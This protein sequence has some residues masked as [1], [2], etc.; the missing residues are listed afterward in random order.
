MKRAGTLSFNV[1]PQVSNGSKANRTEYGTDPAKAMEHLRQFMIA[2]AGSV[3]RA[4]MDFF[5]Q[6]MDHRISKTEFSKGMRELG[7]TGDVFQLFSVLDDDGSNE[8]TLDEIDMK[9]SSIWRNFR[10]FA[11]AMFKSEEDLLQRCADWALDVSPSL[12]KLR[13]D[14]PR[15]DRLTREEFCVGMRKSGW[16]WSVADLNW[17]F[18]ALH[19]QTDQLLKAD[20]LRWLPIELVRKQKKLEAKARSSKYQALQ[21]RTDVSAQA[22]HRHFER[23]KAYL[24]K[25]YGNLIRAWRQ[26]LSQTDSMVLSKLHFLKAASRLGFAK[27]SKDLWKALDKDDSGSA[28][29]DELDPKN[30][31]V[32]AQFKVWMTKKFGG[33]REAF[34]AIDSDSTR[35]ISSS[36]FLSALQRFEFPRPSRQ[37]FSHF[38][39]DGDGKIVL[40]DVLFLESWNPL[41][42]LV[43][44]PNFKAKNEIKKL[45]LVR[46]GQYMK[47]WR[48]LLDKDATNRCNWYEFKDACQVLGYSGDVAG[49]WRAFDDDLSGYI[50]LKEIDEESALVLSNFRK[51]SSLEFGSMK[52]L[53]KVFDA[54]CSG[55]LTFQE[56]RSACHIYGYDGSVR[57]IFSALDVDQQ[58]TLTMKEVLFLD[59][60][61]D[62]EE[63]EGD[64]PQP[65][66]LVPRQAKAYHG[67]STWQLTDPPA[68]AREVIKR[69]RDLHGRAMPAIPRVQLCKGDESSSKFW[70]EKSQSAREPRLHSRQKSFA[71]ANSRTFEDWARRTS[72]PSKSIMSLDWQEDPLS[73]CMMMEQVG[74]PSV[75]SAWCDLP[76]KDL[77]RTDLHQGSLGKPLSATWSP[78]SS[79]KPTLDDLL[80][81]APL[82]KAALARVKR[83]SIDARP[84]TSD[85]S[86]R[87][88]I[89]PG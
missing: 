39:K 56:F 70:P 44:L 62:G 74:L 72:T 84:A 43:V 57:A 14:R 22:K 47:A 71:T 15:V 4:W 49:A 66:A 31:E 24:R 64:G 29:I 81:P 41:P 42:F 46:T 79:A 88:R 26:A 7:Y 8:L 30:A 28:S 68:R 12:A 40:D 27:E 11:A 86:A 60:W 33:V 87:G 80:T 37:L 6:D 82:R 69:K 58:G 50:S 17:I 9:Q 83:T 13:A 52:S 67:P 65:G 54:D 5:D 19:D 51:W 1:K 25:K 75:S 55:S 34:S 2:S 3:L 77:Q 53:F 20:G 76:L 73:T 48:R 10:V 32:L 89:Q 45:I 85:C 21:S 59:D 38:D 61:D 23:F 18:D 35:F 36:E 78:S 63:E 16:T